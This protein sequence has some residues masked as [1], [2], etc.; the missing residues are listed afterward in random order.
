[1]RK[2]MEGVVC[3]SG[4]TALFCIPCFLDFIILDISCKHV[5]PFCLQLKELLLVHGL[6]CMNIQ[7][8]V[9]HI[10]ESSH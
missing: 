7:V 3:I 10:A 6:T 2:D 1:M 9:I 8:H 4:N 5:F